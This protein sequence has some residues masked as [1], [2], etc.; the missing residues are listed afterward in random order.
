MINSLGVVCNGKEGKWKV[1]G[2]NLAQAGYHLTWAANQHITSVTVYKMLDSATKNYFVSGFT[3]GVNSTKTEGIVKGWALNP[4]CSSPSNTCIVNKYEA[5]IGK[6]LTYWYFKTLINNDQT[7]ETPGFLL[8]IQAS[9]QKFKVTSA[10]LRK[11]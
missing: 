2:S 5:P 6:A 7:P 9:S 10:N 11:I 8:D 4:K 3:V 1:L